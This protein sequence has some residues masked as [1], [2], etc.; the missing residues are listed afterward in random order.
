MVFV[1]VVALM[2]LLVLHCQLTVFKGHVAAFL[3]Y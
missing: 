3:M 2:A 1:I